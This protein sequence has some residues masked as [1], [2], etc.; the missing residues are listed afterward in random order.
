MIRLP[1]AIAACTCAGAP[2]G[3]AASPS[4][5]IRAVGPGVW[6]GRLGRTLLSDTFVGE[7]RGSKRHGAW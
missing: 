4:G 6:W 5:G 7:E 3:T 1:A 2:W